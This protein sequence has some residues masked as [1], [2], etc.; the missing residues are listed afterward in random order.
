MVEKKVQQKITI[1][2]LHSFPDWSPWR[3]GYV[4]MIFCSMPAILNLEI[5]FCKS[6]CFLARCVENSDE[7]ELG[8]QDSCDDWSD[9][10]QPW[11]PGNFINIYINIRILFPSAHQD[12]G[13]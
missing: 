7:E 13:L 3:F 1:A 5:H 11:Y 4:D 6:D 8:S 12:F 9:E 2:F 10:I